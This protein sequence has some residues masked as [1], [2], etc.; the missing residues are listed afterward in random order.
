MSKEKQKDLKIQAKY[1]Q[2]P[3]KTSDRL[4]NLFLD[5]LVKDFLEKTDSTEQRG[6]L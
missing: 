2:E 4:Y 1:Q 6:D 3:R 5:H